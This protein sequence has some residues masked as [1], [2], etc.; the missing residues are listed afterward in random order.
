MRKIRVYAIATSP[1]AQLTQPAPGCRFA[2]PCVPQPSTNP[3]PLAANQHPSSS[4]PQAPSASLQRYREGFGRAGGTK[5]DSIL[6]PQQ[7]EV[8]APTDIGIA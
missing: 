4:V 8:C 7:K 6:K 2:E 3:I 5:G 1:T